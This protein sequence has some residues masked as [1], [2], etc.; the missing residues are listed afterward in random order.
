MVLSF[1]C[2]LQ[3]PAGGHGEL[4]ISTLCSS[5]FVCS[6]S[7]HFPNSGRQHSSISPAAPPLRILYKEQAFFS[8]SH[9]Y[10][11]R[12]VF[13]HELFDMQYSHSSC[14][15]NSP[16][17]GWYNS[18][19]LRTIISLILSFQK[20]ILC[21]WKG[22][23]WISSKQWRLKAYPYGTV[24]PEESCIIFPVLYLLNLPKGWE[25]NISSVFGFLIIPNSISNGTNL[26]ASLDKHLPN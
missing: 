9:L 12:D 15:E 18:R 5:C 8:H 1:S 24:A 10:K 7:L 13:Y 11:K 16:W 2:S 25:N 23:A 4:Q 20:Q 17:I 6:S 21:L 26:I 19:M 22:L 3:T 14:S